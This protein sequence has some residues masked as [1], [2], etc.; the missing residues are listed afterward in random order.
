LIIITIILFMAIN[1]LIIAN[2]Q[3]IFSISET[4][5]IYRSDN[6]RYKNALLDS[7]LEVRI[8]IFK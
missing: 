6:Q 2:I 5:T 3:L 7:Q 8:R 4:V 1:I